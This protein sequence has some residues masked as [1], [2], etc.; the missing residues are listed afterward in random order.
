MWLGNVQSEDRYLLFASFLSPEKPPL[1]FWWVPVGSS[2]SQLGLIIFNSVVKYNCQ[3]WMCRLCMQPAVIL[4]CFLINIISA[5]AAPYFT[6]P[7]F[8]YVVH[9]CSVSN[10][11]WTHTLPVDLNFHLLTFASILQNM[12]VVVFVSVQNCWKNGHISSRVNSL[13]RK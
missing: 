10:C 1:I 8:S 4:L 9:I 2:V 13:I 3:Y 12:V 11:R 5:F 7:C 6:L